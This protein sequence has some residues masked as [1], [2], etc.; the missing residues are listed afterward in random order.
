MLGKHAIKMLE[1]TRYRTLRIVNALP[2]KFLQQTIKALDRQEFDSPA[3]ILEHVAYAEQM[4][5]QY[6]MGLK[7]L[8]PIEFT[9]SNKP[10]SFILNKLDQIRKETIEWLVQKSDFELDD[11]KFNRRTNMGW[12]FHHLPEHEAHHIG[13]ICIL[14]L[15]A[16]LEVP[17]V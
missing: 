2:S 8:I 4:Y 5:F 13:Q 7:K 15:M 14:A 11:I 12:V 6:I 16:D 3:K 9:F 1:W 10:K 17:N